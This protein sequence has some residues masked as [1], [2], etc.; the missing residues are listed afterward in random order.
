MIEERE[1]RRKDEPIDRMSSLEDSQRTAVGVVIDRQSWVSNCS[2]Q[3]G[4][5]LRPHSSLRSKFIENEH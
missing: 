5:F 4:G 2:N 3:F 1:R